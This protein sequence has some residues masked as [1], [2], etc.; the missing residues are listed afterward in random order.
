MKI[1]VLAEAPLPGECKKALL[2]AYGP[3]WVAGF[4]A[5]MLRDMLDGAQAITADEYAVFATSGLDVLER[6]V[7]V[8]WRVVAQPEGDHGS[9]IAHAFATFGD[10]RAVLFA[11]DA[12][13]FDVDPLVKTLEGEE[14]E[15]LVIAP[16]ES[17]DVWAFASSRFDP[18]LLRDLP[19]GT[20]AVV[21]TLR[22]RCR[23]LGVAL[24]EVAPWYTIDQPSDVL[25]LLDELRKH[26]DRAPR[27]AQYLV[28]RA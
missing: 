16:S 15:A 24:R 20:P 7:P 3:D 9:R 18:A 4:Y 5:A 1:G 21:E 12:P 19:W 8:P 10:G 22:L 13:S 25:R 11:A 27:A 23:E 14:E 28:T 2:T 26:P 17:G 6:H